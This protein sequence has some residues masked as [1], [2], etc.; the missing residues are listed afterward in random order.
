MEAQFSVVLNEIMADPSPSAGLPDCEYLEVFNAGISTIDLTGWTL[1]LGSRM[2]VL[3]GVVLE[4]GSYLLL[5]GTGGKKKMEN[6]ARTFEISGF[7]LTNTGMVISLFNPGKLLVDQLEYSPAMHSKGF[8]NGG[9]ALERIDPFRRCGQRNNW[10]TSLSPSGGTPGSVNTVRA[11]N[12]DRIP[13]FI[14][15]FTRKDNSLLELRFSESILY[16]STAWSVAGAGLA[17]TRPDTVTTGENNRVVY[18]GFV[19][20]PLQSG[21]D[22]S[23]SIS[24]I[25]DECGNRM[26]DRNLGFGF[27][28][29]AI[30]DILVNEV[31][32]NPFSGG[33]D[34][35]ELYNNS[36][37]PFDLATLRLATRDSLG[38]LRQICPL[39]AS[40]QFFH[41]GSYLAVTKSPDAVCSQYFVR[42]DSC[43]LQAARMPSL[44]DESGCVVLLGPQDL[45]LD[46]MR[47]S[48]AMHHPLVSLDE[49]ISLERVSTLVPA[50]QRDNWHSASGSCGY[51]TPGY[52]NSATATTDTARSVISVEP[53]VFSPNGDGYHDSLEI[54]LN[55]GRP[56]MVLNIM[57]LN[58]EGLPVRRLASNLLAGSSDKLSWDGSGDDNQRLEP[59]IYILSISMYDYRGF[60][61]TV[62]Q[63]C[64]L[65]DTI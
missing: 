27:Y 65:T 6:Y 53:A 60:H 2:K 10:A 46:E 9:Y 35:V 4:P 57:I 1:G 54:N 45:V 56:G 55:P 8:E 47:Y 28:L 24:G 39:S 58:S 51:A 48:A 50:S 42:C 61:R 38:A 34:F 62:R 63:A 21:K 14:E 29:P 30:G 49:G 40:Q 7:S 43:L 32:F 18:L 19:K 25:T 23:L 17:G 37:H 64:V 11:E 36:R 52:R 31:L 26:P 59:G 15:K 12:P 20:N 33:S 3:P 41:A 5:T 13:P 22:Y 16:P 44:G